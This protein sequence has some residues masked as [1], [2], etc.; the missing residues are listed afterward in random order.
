MS[1]VLG[2][3]TCT[4]SHTVVGDSVLVEVHP[5]TGAT[6]DPAVA[7]TIH[8]NGTPGA[9][10]YLQYWT[11]GPQNVLVQATGPHGPESKSVTV[12]VRDIP[13]PPPPHAVGGHTIQPVDFYSWPIIGTPLM[14]IAREPHQPYFVGFSVGEKSQPGPGSPP[15]PDTTV[16]E[17]TAQPVLEQPAPAVGSHTG[18]LDLEHITLPP[19]GRGNYVWYFGDGRSVNTLTPFVQYDFGSAIDPRIEHQSFD[20]TV[21]TSDHLR[22]VTRTVTFTN[23]YGMLAKI[24]NMLHPPA[25]PDGFAQLTSTG[26]FASCTVTNPEEQSL[27]LNRRRFVPWPANSNQA[28]VAAP[29]ENISNTVI[30]QS[31]ALRLSVTPTFAQVPKGSIGFSVYLSG[32]G[33]GNKEVKVNVHF[34]LEPSQR[35]DPSLI[36]RQGPSRIL[37]DSIQQTLILKN[38]SGAIF[39]Q[40]ENILPEASGFKLNRARLSNDL[41]LLNTG[42]ALPGSFSQYDFAAPVVAGNICCPD[43]LPDDIPP[44]MVCQLTQEAPQPVPTPARFQNAWKGHTILSPGGVGIVGQLLTTVDVPQKYSHCGIMTTNFDQI[45]HCTA[46]ED[47]LKAYPEGSIIGVGPKPTH[48]FRVDVV[49]Y[50]W[51]GTMTQTVDGCINGESFP[52]PEQPSKTY[53]FKDFNAYPSG[54]TIDKEWHLVPQLVVKPD[55][56]LE[57]NALRQKLHAVGDDAFA[58]NGKHHYRFY[59]YTDPSIVDDPNQAAPAVGKW[60]D[61]TAPACCSSFIWQMMKRNGMHLAGPDVSTKDSDLTAAQKAAGAKVAATNPLTP[62]GLY[63]YSAAERARAADFLHTQITNQ[64][65]EEIAEG[66]DFHGIQLGG[67]VSGPLELL[68]LIKK[69]VPNEIVNFF[70]GDNGTLN[71]DEEGWRNTKD[72]NAVSPDNIMLW[73]GPTATVPG[74]YGYVEPCRYTDARVDLVPV[75]RWKLVQQ[76]GTVTGTVTY[77]GAPVKSAT[78]SLGGDYT[79]GSDN[80]GHYTIDHVP[81]GR[82]T[83]KA[84]QVLGRVSPDL[85]ATPDTI[86]LT[87]NMPI[88]LEQPSQTTD[89]ALQPPPAARRNVVL[90]GSIHIHYDYHAFIFG[91]D[92]EDNDFP[93]HIE[94]PISILDIPPGNK[95]TTISKNIK[96]AQ[97]AGTSTLA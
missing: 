87:A 54:A 41:H 48:G 30:P 73:N 10:F 97:V 33:P 13:R 56:M 18:N 52:D 51:P 15:W 94:V 78:I 46:Q 22:R 63:L 64:V 40:L 26:H 66:A 67:L 9:H 16:V 59:C 86:L 61:G 58:H 96:T 29:V 8:I 39:S 71:D 77:N 28:L 69:H 49:K 21:A 72:A 23:P 55:P 76:Q 12:Q 93:F 24:T 11:S 7:S 83:L 50:G 2:E 25:E 35:L 57:D 85:S 88:D 32:T 45:T 14:K 84:Q 5:A 34:D 68:T 37:L 31:G 80:N 38:Q 60:Q 4:P 65:T 27:T 53:E 70:A 91:S 3:V 17:V 74:P 6:F 82:Y 20:V 92:I 90:D 95:H 81:Y 62:D 42:T 75:S 89:I 47:R 19:P 36:L 43:N 1:S 79:T 44:G